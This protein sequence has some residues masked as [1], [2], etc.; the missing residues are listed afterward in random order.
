MFDD[1]IKASAIVSPHLLSK[2]Q[3]WRLISG[4]FLMA[5]STFCNIFSAIVLSEIIVADTNES[6]SDSADSFNLP[7]SDL[8]GLFV[9]AMVSGKMLQSARRLITNPLISETAFSLVYKINQHLMSL[10]HR[11]FAQTP[12]G[13]MSEIFTTGSVGAQDFTTQLV[14]QLLPT[15]IESMAATG[16]AFYRFGPGPGLTFMGMF[17]VYIS[18][19]ISVANHI[20]VNQKEVVKA[21]G[22]MTRAITSTLINYEI[23]KLFNN[24]PYELSRVQNKL[25]QVK[26][27]NTKSFSI[28]DKISF[29]QWAIIGGGFTGLLLQT[30]DSFPVSDFVGLCFY[31]LLYV[32]LFNGF[33][34]GLTKAKAACINL[35]QVADVFEKKPDI[36][37]SF[38]NEILH[39]EEGATIVFDNVSFAYEKDKIKPVLKNLSFSVNPGETVGIVGASGAGKSTIAKLL[40]RFYDNHEGTIS[41]NGQDIKTVSIDSLRD[42]IALVSQT[43]TVFNDTIE[44]NIWYGAIS[45]H[46]REIQP[47]RIAE[48][49]SIASL[50]DFIQSLPNGLKTNV[51]ERGLKIS[52]GQLQRLAIARAVVRAA[53]IMIFDEATSAL[54]SKTEEAVQASLTTAA[55]GKATLVIAHKLSNVKAANKIIVLREGA[56]IEEG[57][58]EELLELGGYYAELWQKQSVEYERPEELRPYMQHRS[59]SSDEQKGSSSKASARHN[60]SRMFSGRGRQQNREG[61]QES[62]LGVVSDQNAIEIQSA[63]HRGP[64]LKG[65]GS[66]NDDV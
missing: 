52:G 7:L 41:I 43:S 26:L 10:S 61:L 55:R 30:Y 5:G 12:I 39:A 15:T 3:R 27:V 50:G 49:I 63:L 60:L 45:K 20:A 32:N 38:P 6:P 14:N 42:A 9:V 19:N 28:P 57:T 34:D 58:H 2:E 47:G 23:I 8:V 31:L 46:G 53:P 51:G 66:I 35:A 11:H 24:L 37:D 4:A 16:I 29:G 59:N 36:P 22:E 56:K 62:L 18:Y 33:G 17:V 65:Y 64:S 1:I 21:K 13:T 25:D 48:A 40:C 54:D 44:N